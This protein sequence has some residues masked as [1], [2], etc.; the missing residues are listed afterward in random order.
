LGVHWLPN[1][2]SLLRGVACIP[3]V[4][5][6]GAGAQAVACLVFS[7]AALTD[8]IDGPLARRLGAVSTFGAFLDPLADKALVLGTLMGL[9][10]RGATDPTPV[11]LILA[12]EAIVT[13]VR[14]VAAGRG[15]VIRSTRDGKV[16]ACLQGA[17]VGAQLIVLTWPDLGLRAIADATLWSAAA[18]TLVT[19]IAVVRRAVSAIA[20]VGPST[21]RAHAR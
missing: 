12:R 18:A 10:A 9:L 3:V 19:G 13:G 20:A 15:L 7:F 16:K 4:L 2:I 1:A 17:A 11:G 21:M 5:L 14:A 8:A 6:L